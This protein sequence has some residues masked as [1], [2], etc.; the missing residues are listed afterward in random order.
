MSP[1]KQEMIK[2]IIT[3]AK[4]SEEEKSKIIA[5]IID[6]FDKNYPDLKY[7]ATKSDVKES[8]LKLIKEIEKTRKEIKEIE[9]KLFQEIEKTRK[10]IKEIELKLSKEIKE[11]ENKLQKEIK[12]TELKLSKEIKEVEAKLSKEIVETKSTLLKWTFVFWV[13]QISVILG[14]GFFVVKLLIH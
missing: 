7:H 1:A 4:L 9:F 8:E 5:E 12:E 3:N 6:E 2:A 14:V 10:E 11:T 13:S